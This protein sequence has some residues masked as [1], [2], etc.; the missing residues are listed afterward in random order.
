M[1]F[2]Q[3]MFSIDQK[4]TPDQV[5]KKRAM[6]AALMPRY[7][8]AKYV[9]EGL[10]Q[11]AHG[12]MTGIQNRKLDKV[13]GEGAAGANDIFSRLMGRQGAAQGGGAGPMSVLGIPP[14]TSQPMPAADSGMI[15]AQGGGSF[16]LPA[17]DAGGMQGGMSMPPQKSGGLDFGGL[18]QQYGLP[19]GYLANVAQ[20][21]SG[22]DPN[23]QNPNS[24]AGGMFQ[25]ID[26]TAKQYGVTDRFDPTQAANGAARLAADNAAS[27]RKVLGREP[28][29]GELYLAH[30]QGAGGASKLLS[31]P[32]A[33]ASAIVGSEAVRLNGGT[34]NMTA[35]E[36]ANKWVSKV[37][38]GQGGEYAPPQ[39]PMT[40]LYAAMQSPWMNDQQRAMIGSMIDQQTQA[41]DPMQQMQMQKARIEL[42]QMQNP[43][44]PKPIEVGGVL[45]DPT[46][47]QPI[48][49]SRVQAGGDGFTLGAGQQRYD[50]QGNMIASGPEAVA[51]RPLNPQERQQWGIPATDTRPYAI[52]SGKP[53]QLIGG[54]G[55]TVNNDIGG[56]GKFEEAFA[57][58]DADTVASVYNSGLSAQRNLG[59][60][61]QLEGLLSQSPTGMQGA[62]AQAAGEW[63]INTEGLDAVQSAQ[64]IINSLVPEQRQPGSGPMSDAD[65][66]LFKQSL[67]RIINQP[68]GNKTI[69][70]TMR[71]I[72]QYDAE[73]ASIVQRLRSG[74]LTRPQAFE[75]LQSRANPLSSAQGT[76]GQPAQP[77][78]AGIPDDLTPEEKAMLGL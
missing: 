31:N 32:N 12:V 66:A 76:A 10:G 65:L 39:I 16:G 11:L 26:S 57:K 74:E 34:D 15:G 52:E 23:A 28:T 18:E 44:A 60:I 77:T 27:L 69:V 14:E 54:G 3:G 24:S 56:G 59:R 29:A 55:V 46:T 70:D 5:A 75:A 33:L 7:G 72:A 62:L 47:Y 64:A 25:F 53:P 13:E 43:G 30:Q 20:I 42:D 1:T 9:G 6:I 2:A 67:P 48:F 63:G 50:A 4:A 49:D 73:G 40:E 17:A 35:G 61:D 19:A 45:L 68:G 41:A 38:G 58:G 36:F 51:P 21:E 78:G 71:A 8:S 22:G 37:G